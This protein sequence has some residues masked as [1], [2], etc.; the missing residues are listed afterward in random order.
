MPPISAGRR[1]VLDVRERALAKVDTL[2]VSNKEKT[3]ALLV[4]GEIVIGGKQNRAL[5]VSV[6]IP[7]GADLDVPVSCVEA[8]RWTA[9]RAFG[10]SPS[11]ATR[12]VRRADIVTTAQNV[13]RTGSKAADQAQV[14]EAVD[15]ELARTG[16]QSP[17][18][19][20]ADAEAVVE[21]DDTLGAALAEVKATG[22][23]PGQCGVVVAQGSHVVAA[24]IFGSPE[25]LADQWEPVVHS[26]FLD[27]EGTPTGNPSFSAALR[28]LG[29]A[30]KAQG[31]EAAGV[32]L[33]REF[34]LESSAIVGQALLL[35]EFVVHAV[36]LPA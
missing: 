27:R 17:T 6:L 5:N 2:S 20:L 36:V 3:A 19:S 24:E 33:G 32:G 18:S 1:A 34:H 28:L 9:P 4:A 35:E 7:A 22:P 25:L 13:R 29:R 10:R 14:W 31:T 21:R 11:F 12:A 15:R 30:S 23:L 16:T 8:G 26:A